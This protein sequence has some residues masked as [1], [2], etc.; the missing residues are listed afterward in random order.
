MEEGYM[1]LGKD[2]ILCYFTDQ[3]GNII[4]PFES[5]AF[6]CKSCMCIQGKQATAYA[7]IVQYNAIADGKKQIYTNQDELNE[8]GDC[9]ILDPSEVSYYQVYVNGQL[10]PKECYDIRAGRIY[11]NEHYIPSKERKI[12][13]VF[14]Q[15][16]DSKGILLSGTVNYYSTRADG[17]SRSFKVASLDAK[18]GMSQIPNEDEVSAHNLY[19]NGVLQPKITYKIMN[20]E[21]KIVT[22]D[23]PKKGELIMLES[24][25]LRGSSGEKVS[26]K[27]R[28][29]N[30]Y[31][32]KKKAYE[33]SDKIE[34]YDS[35]DIIHPA[36]VSYQKLYI[37]AMIQPTIVYQIKECALILN[38]N[39]TPLVGEP[40]TLQSITSP[41][42]QI[43]DQQMQS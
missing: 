40:I 38:T 15:L 22:D 1:I 17:V 13:I 41:I 37:N 36:N 19:I 6:E 20:H 28:Q 5:N 33:N 3:S 32:S 7:N 42:F 9:G 16:Y 18:D 30:A 12:S 27:E 2:E 23:L 21:L 34:M 24:L 11:F 43:C 39:T 25:L 35:D 4:N 10:Y 29:Y 26:L 8:Y 31:G 14:F